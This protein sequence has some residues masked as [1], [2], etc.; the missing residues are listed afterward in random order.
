MSLLTCEGGFGCICQGMLSLRQQ[1]T[2]SLLEYLQSAADIT[3]QLSR[4]ED[5]VLSHGWSA[6]LTQPDDMTRLRQVI[7]FPYSFTFEAILAWHSTHPQYDRS[8]K[9]NK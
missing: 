9:V 3:S 6:T 7:T 5:K 8:K 1:N 4:V 2:E